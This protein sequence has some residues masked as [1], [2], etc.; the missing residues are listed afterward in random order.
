M[1]VS[2]MFLLEP[3]AFQLRSR[4]SIANTHTTMS[5]MRDQAADCAR[6]QGSHIRHVE[7]AART[8]PERCQERGAYIYYFW[9]NAVLPAVYIP[10][11][12][13]SAEL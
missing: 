11:P 13:V 12:S 8:A 5:G 3:R 1:G 6:S 2:D 9:R 7:S 10:E 4:S